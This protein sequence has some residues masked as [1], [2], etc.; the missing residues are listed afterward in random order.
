MDEPYGGWNRL[1][2][3]G[4][5]QK[6]SQVVATG[7]RLPDGVQQQHADGGIGFALLHR[8]AQRAVHL[9][10]QC[11]FLLGTVDGDTQHRVILLALNMTH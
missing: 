5:L 10:G 7:K 6:V 3:P 4:F 1:P 2:G 9:R 8:V 11:I